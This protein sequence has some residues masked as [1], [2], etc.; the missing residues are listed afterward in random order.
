MAGRI[1]TIKP[2]WRTDEKLKSASDEARVLSVALITL[3]DD[4]GNGEA[5]ELTIAGQVW[6]TQGGRDPREVLAK[7]S[8]A[9]D[10]LVEIGY[11]AVYSISGSEFFHLVNWSR[12]Q[13]VDKPGKPRYPGPLRAEIIGLKSRENLA[14]SSREF[15]EHFQE[16]PAPDQDQDQDQD[17]DKERE[18][19]PDSRESRETL[20]TPKAELEQRPG[21]RIRPIAEQVW[22]E[23]EELR[24]ELQLDGIGSDTRG[25]GMVHPAKN[26]LVHRIGEQLSGG[27]DA[28]EALGDCRHVLAVIE[29][30]CRE[31]AT[32]K[33]LDGGHW[34]SENFSR[35]MTRAV[36]ESFRSDGS[37]GEASFADIM[38]ANS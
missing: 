21:D 29:H 18:K 24:R 16:S 13:R 1:R 36:G 8:R 19:E 25:L 32:L 34:K 12:H 11:L 20:A 37:H 17:Q 15:R 10:E 26:E 14:N 9:I 4:Y 31:Q 30:D 28:E 38:G 22:Q 35:A 23:Q 6:G 27:K 7:A 2:E 5:G 3:S 33:W